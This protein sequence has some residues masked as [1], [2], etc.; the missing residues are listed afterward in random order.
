MKRGVCGNQEEDANI[1]E[2]ASSLG[3]ILSLY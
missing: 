1:E 2:A 3:L